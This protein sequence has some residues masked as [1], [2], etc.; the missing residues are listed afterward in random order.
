MGVNHDQFA[1]VGCL[2]LRSV[3]RLLNLVLVWPQK[4]NLGQDHVVSACT[5]RA[6]LDFGVARVIQRV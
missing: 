3:A 6:L 4:R 2:R 5:Q 1:H